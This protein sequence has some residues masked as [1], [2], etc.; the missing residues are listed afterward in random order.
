MVNVETKL[1]SQISLDIFSP[2]LPNSASFQ[3][4]SKFPN[5]DFIS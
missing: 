4:I 5:A 3:R 1:G 2:V